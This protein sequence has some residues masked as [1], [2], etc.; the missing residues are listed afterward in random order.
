MDVLAHTLAST[1][2][3][4]HKKKTRATTTPEQKTTC[5]QSQQTVVVVSKAL[6]S[7]ALAHSQTVWFQW[8]CQCFLST[9]PCLSSH[10]QKRP[11]QLQA[12]PRRSEA[13]SSWIFSQR[14][15]RLLKKFRFSLVTREHF[16]KKIPWI[17]ASERVIL[18]PLQQSQNV[19]CER[20]T[21]D[22]FVYVNLTFSKA[23]QETGFVEGGT[24]C[25]PFFLMVVANLMFIAT[26]SVCT[27]V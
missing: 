24:D 18:L 10:R 4:A 21:M 8:R 7:A 17:K 13:A 9:V 20:S 23:R 6:P 2:R 16:Q 25:T 5:Q 14:R 27:L 12:I 26:M 1:K 22:S 15:L 3:S 11:G 19:E